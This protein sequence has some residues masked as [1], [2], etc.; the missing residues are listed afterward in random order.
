MNPIFPWNVVSKQYLLTPFVVGAAGAFG[1]AGAAGAVGA[2]G[3]GGAAGAGE[4]AEGGA[5]LTEQ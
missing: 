1:A 4:A 5:T 2:I 3:A